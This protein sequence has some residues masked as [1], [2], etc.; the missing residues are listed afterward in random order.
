LEA[1]LTVPAP[2]ALG[3]GFRAAAKPRRYVT[4]LVKE[5]YGA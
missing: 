1:A 4:V 5:I 2:V 3:E